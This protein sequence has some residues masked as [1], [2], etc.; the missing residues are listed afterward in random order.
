V[1]LDE[2]YKVKKELVVDLQ[3]SLGDL[4]NRCQ[5]I[6]EESRTNLIKSEN[7][8]RCSKEN[9]KLRVKVWIEDFTSRFSED[10]KTQTLSKENTESVLNQTKQQNIKINDLLEYPQKNKL[11]KS[12]NETVNISKHILG[13]QDNLKI[14][15]VTDGEDIEN[16]FIP[17]YTIHDCIL[18][19]INEHTEV[20]TYLYADEFE[21]VRDKF[22]LGAKVIQNKKNKSV[23]ISLRISKAN[24]RGKQ[25][26]II[27]LD[28]RT[29]KV[30]GEYILAVEKNKNAESH[31]LHSD[32]MN[33]K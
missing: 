3:N 16:H 9:F 17:K 23:N 13:K 28:L 10:I 31:I 12:F 4:T 7:N 11:V 15:D 30:I 33:S 18:P 5:D 8:M 2:I 25:Y 32:V 20:G 27:M 14:S 19:V 29:N 26:E 1:S 22:K 24:N 21:V 6:L